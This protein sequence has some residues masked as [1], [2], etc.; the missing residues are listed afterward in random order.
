MSTV[1]LYQVLQIEPDA[2]NK[3]IKKAFRTLAKRYHPDQ[4]NGDEDLFELVAEA[5]AVLKDE[6]KRKDY[7]QVH[8]LSKQSNTDH[9]SLKQAALDYAEGL[10][11]S[12][13]TDKEAEADFNMLFA[14]MDRKNN[15]NRDALDDKLSAKD[16]K[17]HVNDLIQAREQ[18]DIEMHQE[19]IF[20]EDHFD[21]SKFNAAFDA[22]YGQT[23]AMTLHQ[24]GPAAWTGADG[25]VGAGAGLSTNYSSL[26]DYGSLYVNDENHA[27]TDGQNFSSLSSQ[28]TQ[29]RTLNMKDVRKLAG[30]DYTN[31][32]NAI[33]ADYNK[34]LEDLI[35]ERNA[36]T[37]RYD[38]REMGDFSTNP[39]CGGYG[40]FDQLGVANNSMMT[41]DNDNKKKEAYRAL[42][43]SRKETTEDSATS[44]N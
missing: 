40:V 30:A 13:K 33:D 37:E 15:F 44:N 36:E 31:N 16:T 43:E 21:N 41:W 3:E 10:Q 1:D 39:D 22:A 19:R 24:G 25:G 20:E 8:L 6:K 12:K 23:S 28:P 4:E 11:T 27:G 34:S 7:D 42:L 29:K 18:D 38:N 17:R 26:D 9:N 14:E 2:T 32:H 5:Y 35:R